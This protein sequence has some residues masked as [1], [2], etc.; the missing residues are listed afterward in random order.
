MHG[1]TYCPGAH[2][3]MSVAPF[4]FFLLSFDDLCFSPFHSH[5][6]SEEF[7]NFHLAFLL[8]KPLLKVYVTLMIISAFSVYSE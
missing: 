5:A 1:D 4:L 8:L 2:T 7:L 6:F 3:P